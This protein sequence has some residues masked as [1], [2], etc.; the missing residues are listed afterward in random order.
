MSCP[1]SNFTAATQSSAPP[2]RVPRA[3]SAASTPG[4]ETWTRS[5]GNETARAGRRRVHVLVV[6]P[7]R[8]PTAPRAPASGRRPSRRRTAGG[9]AACAEQD[10]AQPARMRNQYVGRGRGDRSVEQHDAA[11]G[12]PLHDAVEGGQRRHLGRG[13]APGMGVLAHRKAD[14]AERAADLAVVGV[15]SARP[16]GIVDPVG[17]DEMDRRHSGRS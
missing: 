9:R 3:S 16:G 4:S 2:V 15:A 10:Q 8:W 7:R 17:Y 5:A 12:D 1:L 13:Q 6:T 11:V 14:R